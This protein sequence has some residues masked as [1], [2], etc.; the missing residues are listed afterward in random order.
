MEDIKMDDTLYTVAEVAKILKMGK[1]RVYDLIK[2]ELIPVL[3]L[4]G[5]KIRKEAVNQFWEKYEGY[6]LTDLS[7][8]RKIE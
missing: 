5:Y 6:D 1:N 8:I 7:N 4:G 3:I 2:T